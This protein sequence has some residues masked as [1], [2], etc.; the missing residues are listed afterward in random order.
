[1][2]FGSFLLATR[3]A[4]NPWEG[5]LWAWY[6]RAPHGIASAD[7]PSFQGCIGYYQSSYWEL[8][9]H[10]IVWKSSMVALSQAWVRFL[11][12]HMH[13]MLGWNAFAVDLGGSLAVASKGLFATGVSTDLSGAFTT[14]DTFRLVLMNVIKLHTWIPV[15]KV[16]NAFHTVSTVYWAGLGVIRINVS[17]YRSWIDFL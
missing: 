10:R 8:H 1:M 2:L 15:G 11:L 9:P 5:G 14:L 3:H 7:A 6:Q 4:C 16:G 12:L 17:K 13:D